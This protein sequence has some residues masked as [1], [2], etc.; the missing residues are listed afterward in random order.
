VGLAVVRSHTSKTE[1][2]TS[3][4]AGFATRAQ[5]LRQKNNKAPRRAA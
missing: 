1:L 5:Y 2:R 4:E 3:V